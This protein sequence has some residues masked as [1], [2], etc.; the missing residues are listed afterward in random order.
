MRI[1]KLPNV[2]AG[3][4]TVVGICS[5]ALAFAANVFFISMPT[6]SNYATSLKR[7]S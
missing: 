7:R 4:A 3:K 6:L 5:T 1:P 2:S